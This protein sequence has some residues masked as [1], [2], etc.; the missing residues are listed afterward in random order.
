[1]A[2]V[3]EQYGGGGSSDLMNPRTGSLVLGYGKKRLARC[4]KEVSLNEKEVLFPSN[5]SLTT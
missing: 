2:E 3:I 4:R 5:Y 1:M